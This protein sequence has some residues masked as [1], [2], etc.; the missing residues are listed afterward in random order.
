LALVTKYCETQ[1]EADMFKKEHPDVHC[2]VLSMEERDRREKQRYDEDVD[3]CKRRDASYVA[4]VVNGGDYKKIEPF[5]YGLEILVAQN[6]ENLCEFYLFK[7]CGC[8]GRVCLEGDID[9]VGFFNRCENHLRGYMYITKPLFIGLV[10]AKM[11]N[12][13]VTTYHHSF[14]GGHT[15][16]VCNPDGSHREYYYAR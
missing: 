1:E 14:R 13:V 4:K 16:Y 8:V 12:E 6:P 5:I 7:M 9:H 15:E 10:K 2:V 3:R 11:T